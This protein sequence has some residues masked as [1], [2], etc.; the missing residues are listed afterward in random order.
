M[1]C[2]LY[3]TNE[4][5]WQYLRTFSDLKQSDVVEAIDESERWHNEVQHDGASALLH[6]RV[7]HQ[8]LR[9]ERLQ[10]DQH[11]APNARGQRC[12]EEFV[13]YFVPSYGK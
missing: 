9:H 3:Q 6:V 8:Q 10:Q 5:D 11:Q 2:S 4:I 1:S 7:V 13:D 12:V